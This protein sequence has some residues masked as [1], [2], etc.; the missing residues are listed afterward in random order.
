MSRL[1]VIGAA[2]YQVTAIK[3]IKELGHE[4]YCVD[5]KNGAPGFLISNGYKIIDVRDKANCLKYARSLNVDG[6]LTWGSSL[7]L[8]TTSYVASSMSLP[9]LSLDTACLATNKYKIRKRLSECGLNVSGEAFILK[10]LDEIQNHEYKIPLVVKPC[11]GSGSKGVKIVYDK[12]F[13][14]SSLKYAFDNARNNEIYIE[15]FIK[16]DE[17]SVEAY[18]YNGEIFIYSIVK[19]KFTWKHVFP[20]YT[21]TT[22]LDVSKELE[23]AI[24]SEIK[25]AVKALNINFGPA[26]FDLIVSSQDNKPYIIDVG[27]RNGQ[28]LIASH[29]IPYSRGVDELNNQINICLGRKINVK[30]KKMEYISSRLLI[31]SP[32]EIVDIKPFK[33]LIG[34]N[35]IV[36]IIMRKK[37][38]DMLSHYE[39]KADICGWVLTNGKTPEEA[40]QYSNEAWEILKKYIIIRH[41]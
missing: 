32:G 36:D 39:T 7:T 27:I 22:Y 21:Q 16:G 10:N 40:L 17:Y 6:V 5:Y 25:K 37:T 38:G 19:T 13:L 24:E 35:H 20:E 12:A 29:I 11:D 30:P 4:V 23:C 9:S 2:T 26:N 3:R 15:P 1:L 41:V 28:N 33:H 8:E 14:Y 34:N 31:Y 18:A